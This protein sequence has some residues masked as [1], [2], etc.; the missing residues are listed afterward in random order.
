MN[1]VTDRA[2]DPRRWAPTIFGTVMGASTAKV[3]VEEGHSPAETAAAASTMYYV[4]ERGAQAAQDAVLNAAEDLFF[5]KTPEAIR[6][7]YRGIAGRFGGSSS[8]G[9]QKSKKVRGKREAKKQ[10]GP[11]RV[12]NVKSMRRSMDEAQETLDEIQTGFALWESRVPFRYKKLEIYE[13]TYIPWSLILAGEG[14]NE[15]HYSNEIKEGLEELKRTSLTALQANLKE[16]YD[17]LL[18]FQQRRTGTLPPAGGMASLYVD[19]D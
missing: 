4:S 8:R 5:R 11:T 10:S 17:T 16:D 19:I 2:R 9:V 14:D 6:K 13:G 15:R 1:F 7:A 3:M 12:F 18:D